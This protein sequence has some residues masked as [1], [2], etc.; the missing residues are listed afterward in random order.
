[1]TKLEQLEQMQE[2]DYTE[3]HGVLRLTAAEQRKL[4]DSV[5]LA[6][7]AHKNELKVVKR[8]VRPGIEFEARFYVCGYDIRV[9]AEDLELLRFKFIRE[10]QT[11]KRADEVNYI[12]DL[13]RFRREFEVDRK[14]YA[15]E[16]GKTEYE[17]QAD[18]ECL[19]E[20]AASI[21]IV[22]LRLLW[23]LRFYSGDAKKTV[24]WRL[25]GYLKK[26]YDKI[27][28]VDLKGVAVKMVL[29]YVVHAAEG[30]LSEQEE[31][32]TPPAI[33]AECATSS[34]IKQSEVA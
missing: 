18:Y 26:C 25:Y 2:W 11:A 4:P 20:A 8:W 7:R 23:L 29:D 1:M 12:A 16:F 15:K 14:G 13:E 30:N 9:T 31:R 32:T 24:I 27:L 6:Y 33:P 21:D 34:E 17:I 10:A 19:S 5:R 22:D 3:L 28:S